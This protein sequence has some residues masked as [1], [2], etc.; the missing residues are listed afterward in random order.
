MKH[1]FAAFVICAAFCSAAA[2]AQQFDD[3][4]S[5]GN[6][7][8]IDANGLVIPLSQER[9]NAL[10]VMMDTLLEPI[11][12][13]LNRQVSQRAISLKRL[14]AEVRRIVEQHELLPDAIRY[15]GGLTSID[16]I[17]LV[18]EEND[19]LLVGT[20]EGWQADADGNV[21]GTHSGLPLLMFEDFL[22]ALRLWNQPNAPRMV[23]CEFAPTA[24][25]RA[26]LVRLHRQFTSINASNAEAYAAALEEAHGDVPIVISGVSESSRFARILV[27]ADFAM[28]RIALG[29]ESS[30]VRGIPSYVSLLA[31]NR[32]GVSPQFWL[33][34]EYAATTHDSRKLTWRLGDVRVRTTPRETGGTDRA[35]VTWSRNFEGNYDALVRINPVFGE[36][37]NKMMLA[38]VAALIHQENLLQR[39]NCGLTILLDERNLRLLDHPVPMSV[40]YRAVQSRSGG[41]AI[42]VGGGIE[43]SPASAV[44][45]N[46]RLDNRIDTERTRLLQL[47]GTG[48]WLQ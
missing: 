39:A 30:R 12:A 48:W 31:T 33:T 7:I 34:P 40:E 10:G 9:A 19:I 20:G 6:G 18:P 16:Y 27:A 13:S 23:S 3:L 11:P 26:R 43:I 21:V 32:P 22:V 45:T 2:F 1:L 4:R 47:T 5:A 38:L 46:L 42:V 25:A 35:A 14:D 28:K 17:V 44:R 29:L 36:L 15:L 24:E 8:D 41:M 37:R